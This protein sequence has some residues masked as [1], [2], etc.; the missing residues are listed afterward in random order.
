M[1]EDIYVLGQLLIILDLYGDSRH[2]RSETER[3]SMAGYKQNFLL[4][5]KDLIRKSFL[6]IVFCLKKL[7][8]GWIK[9]QQLYHVRYENTALK[10]QL[11]T[12]VILLTRVK[13]DLFVVRKTCVAI[14]VLESL[15]SIASCVH[16][17]IQTVMNTSRKSALQ[18]FGFHMSAMDVKGLENVHC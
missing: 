4:M 16:P 1:E 2:E 6:K 5:M 7:V 9:I 11:D 15:L 10:L 13:T 18:G 14:N 12:Q 3:M 17:V 8:A